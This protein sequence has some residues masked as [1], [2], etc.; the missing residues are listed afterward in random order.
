MNRKVVHIVM[1]GLDKNGMDKGIGYPYSVFEEREDAIKFV[2]DMNQ[3][4]SPYFYGFWLESN[5]A[6]TP[7]ASTKT[8]VIHDVGGSN[9]SY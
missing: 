5:K 6:V 2:E 1:A 7:E 3:K 9:E 8:Q 4:P